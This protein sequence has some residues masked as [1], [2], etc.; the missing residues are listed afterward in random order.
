MITNGTQDIDERGDSTIRYLCL[1]RVLLGKTLVSDSAPIHSLST[2]EGRSLSSARGEQNDVLLSSGL[3]Q[4]D[5]VYS[6]ASE[7]YVVMNPTHVL[8]EFLI[9]F[10]FIA[11]AD[12][13]VAGVG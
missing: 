7:E 6:P 4:Y 11:G 5:S 2:K 12:G 13:D 1:C 9:Q 3:A 10:K 8:P